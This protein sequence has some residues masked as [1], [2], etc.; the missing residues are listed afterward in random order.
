MSTD[1]I[2]LIAQFGFPIG[3]CIYM[4]HTWN[5]KLD[6]LTTVVDRLAGIILALSKTDRRDIDV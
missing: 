1:I 3:L 5:A 4:V 2:A 6:R